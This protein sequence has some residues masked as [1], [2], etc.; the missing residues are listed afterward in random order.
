MRIGLVIDGTDHFFKPIEAELRRRH[1]V[2]HFVPRFVRLP[3]IGKRVNDWLL[4]SQLKAFLRDNDVVFCEWAGEL[5]VQA[6]ALPK[7]GRLV[8]RLHSIELATAADRVDWRMVDTVIVLSKPILSR[9]RAIAKESGTEPAHAELVPNGV[10][11]GRFTMPDRPFGYRLGMACR[12]IPI[13]RVY[14]VILAVYALSQQG[15]PYTLRIA[16]GWGEGESLR[17]RW[18][19]EALV[20]RLNLEDAVHFDGYVTD[21]E[22]WY[23]DVDVF[24][25][26]SYSEGQ[27]VALLEAMASG[28]Y[29][30]SHCWAGAE[31]VLP[32]EYI[33]VTDQELREKLMVYAALPEEEKRMHQ[34]RMRAIAEERFDERRMVAEIVAL[35]EEAGRIQ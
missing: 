15:L 10:D 30:L 32:P 11:L 3:L 23:K 31:E 25:S 18:G 34:R 9:L 20:E 17:Y 28:C 24:L 19:V 4:V 14:E 33:Y 5:L 27:Q 7:S 1:D 8:A 16:G 12:I 22:N 13:K 35:I 26:N 21:V 29:C 2:E 6:T